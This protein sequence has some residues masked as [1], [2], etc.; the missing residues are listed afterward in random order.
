M[1]EKKKNKTDKQMHVREIEG[2]PAV[3][4]QA[5]SP[6][7][8]TPRTPSTLGFMKGGGMD[9]RMDADTLQHPV[10]GSTLW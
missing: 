3:T 6:E 2:P 7:S 9:W 10:R 5:P 4:P 1:V 8:S